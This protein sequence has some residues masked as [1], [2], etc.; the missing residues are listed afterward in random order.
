MT[1]D[2]LR[3]LL[4]QADAAADSSPVPAAALVQRVRAQARRRQTR[5]RA[6]VGAASVLAAIMVIVA[7]VLPPPPPRTNVA[8]NLPVPSNDKPVTGTRDARDLAAELAAIRTQAAASEA[9]VAAML[10]GEARGRKLASVTPRPPDPLERI[11]A[12]QDRGAMA[13]VRQADRQYRELD[14]KASATA[15]YGRVV[16]LFPRTRWAAVARQRL[17][18]IG[19]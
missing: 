19:G 10:K 12:E 15:G 11:R 7:I 14:R 6:A 3:E 17:A 2:G 8:T 16:Q 5:R 18:D 4:A 9:C 1:H 13:L